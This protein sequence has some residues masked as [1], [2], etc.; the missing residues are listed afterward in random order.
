M[1]V[2]A[3]EPQTIGGVLD[4]GFKLFSGGLTAIMPFAY[5]G[6]L[7]GALG[8]WVMQV[9]MLNAM[10]GGGD[11]VAFFGATTIIGAIVI[12]LVTTLFSAAALI[13]A[14]DV[15]YGVQGS[16]GS[17]LGA[18]FGRLFPV[19]FAGLLYGIAVSLG[20]VALIIPG[21][22]LSISLAMCVF[23]AATDNKGPLE[24]LSYSYDIVKGNW[25]RTA[26]VFAVIFIIAIVFY[27]AIGIVAAIF[28]V[29]DSGNVTDFAEPSLLVDVIIAP[30]LTA[31]ATTLFYCLGF[32]VY[33]DLK[34]R[35]EGGDLAD[36]IE[37]LGEE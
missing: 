1:I 35:K 32:A 37:G 9:M 4:S 24:S 17:A 14:R 12:W 19:F 36:R 21:L 5:L 29:A 13:R 18:A 28:I 15:Y 25:W 20:L 8:G 6:S 7:L 22:F 33:E 26:G 16:F 31:I 2:R 11:P 3:N 27:F 23:A 30:V 34:L 10:Q